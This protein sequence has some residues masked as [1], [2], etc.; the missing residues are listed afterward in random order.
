[1]STRKTVLD[2]LA[3]PACKGRLALEAQ[4][5][6]L[7][8]QCQVSYEPQGSIH[9]L[10]PSGWLEGRPDMAL[11]LEKW[12]HLYRQKS[13]LDVEREAEAYQAHIPYIFASGFP[14]QHYLRS[15][16]APVYLEIGSGPGFLALDLARRGYLT[17]CIDV[18]LEVLKVARDRFAQDGLD[19]IFVQGDIT[20]LPLQNQVV[21]LAYGGGVIEH[22]ANTQDVVNELYRVAMPGGA[23][24]NT[25]PAL[26]LFTLTYYQRWGNIPDLPVLRPLFYWFHSRLLGGHHMRYGYEMSF[27]RRKLRAI[28]RRAGFKTIQIGLFRFGQD[29]WHISKSDVTTR[30]RGVKRLLAHCGVWLYNCYRYLYTARLFWNVMYV[31]CVR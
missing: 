14:V 15:H 20:R 31:R 9:R 28:C 29:T 22:F 24:F 21:A 30:F 11:S 19:G 2:L 16:D 7:C 12:E 18:S 1:M 6:L 4:S 27:T 23:V 8:T 13:R 26:S 25:V 17:I 5:A 10:L 3:C